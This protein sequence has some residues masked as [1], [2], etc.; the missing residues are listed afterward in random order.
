VRPKVR[1]RLITGAEAVRKGSDAGVSSPT[2]ESMG[3][4]EDDELGG[5]EFPLFPW[6]GACY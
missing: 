3:M 5:C 4:S 2:E 6:F 1:G